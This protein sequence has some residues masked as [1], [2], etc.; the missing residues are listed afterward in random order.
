MFTYLL[1]NLGVKDVQF[2]ELIA[3]HADHLK[4]RRCVNENTAP[5]LARYYKYPPPPTLPSPRAERSRP[6]ATSNT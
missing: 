5:T 6:S 4:Q 1:E 2:E 3:L